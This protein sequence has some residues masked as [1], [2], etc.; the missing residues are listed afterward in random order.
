MYEHLSTDSDT[1]RLANQQ[2]L[3]KQFVP[4][5]KMVSQF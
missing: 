3:N 1:V 4:V 2:Q 5:D